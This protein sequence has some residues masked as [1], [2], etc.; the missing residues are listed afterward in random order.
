MTIAL[1]LAT[2][3]V[4][5]RGNEWQAWRALRLTSEEPGEVPPIPDQDEVGGFIG[6]SGLPSTGAT[7]EALCHLKVLGLADSGAAA[8]ASDWLSDARTPAGAWLDRPEE[9]PGEFE[10]PGVA[11]VWATASS[12]CGLLA[13]GESPGERALM[14]L[15]GEADNDGRFTG[16]GYTTFAAAGAYWLAAGP[17]SEMSEWALRWAR[18]VGEEWWGPWEWATGLTF[19][20]AAEI[21]GEHP[22]VEMFI[23]SLQDAAPAEGWSDDLGLTLRTL[24]LVRSLQGW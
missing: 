23:E 1:D 18:E 14:L 9:V 4:L 13:V 12:C 15:R 16:G 21:P 11:R 20:A 6:P 3:L 7:G 19:W 17:K 24:E 2:E 5:E 10:N 8:L 22:S